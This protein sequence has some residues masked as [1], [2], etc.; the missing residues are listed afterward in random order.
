M[1]YNLFS[2]K[3][4]QTVHQDDKNV[5][6]TLVDQPL[7]EWVSDEENPMSSQ[8][9]RN[10]R[11]DRVKILQAISHTSELISILKNHS[12]NFTPYQLKDVELYLVIQ[13]KYAKVKLGPSSSVYLLPMSTFLFESQNLM[14][15][16]SKRK[17][18]SAVTNWWN[19]MFVTEEVCS[20]PGKA[21]FPAFGSVRLRP[22]LRNKLDTIFNSGLAP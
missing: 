11:Y 19:Q 12:D 18:K 6:L 21:F 10:D 16:E 13:S 9:L 22:I 1:I 5:S 3:L 8:L 2:V 14:G 17:T 20:L 4:H 15:D 7:T